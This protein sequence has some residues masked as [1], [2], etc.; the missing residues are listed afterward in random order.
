MLRFELSMK[1]LNKL[2]KRI[3]ARI[4]PKAPVYVFHHIPKCGGSSVRKALGEWFIRKKDYRQG[5]SDE[6]PEKYD[7]SQFRSIHCLCGHFGQ[8]GNRIRDRY[9]EVFESKRF[10][11][12]TIAREPLETQKSLYRYLIAKGQPTEAT[13]E[14]HLT[15]RP[16]YIS[17]VLCVDESNYRE[18]LDQYFFIGLI[19]EGQRSLDLLARLIGKPSVQLP[20]SNRT[21]QNGENSG[22]V[23]SAA[24]IERFKQ[25]NALD[26]KVYAYCKMRFEAHLK[27]LS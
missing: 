11:V 8:E 9:P 19:E 3:A 6:S 16:N 18:R 5:W 26:Y 7:L 25:A 27:D 1:K 21:S 20:W 12:F 4:G 22:D 17:Q 14:A 13:L 15:T 24:T 10:R 2:K 23:L